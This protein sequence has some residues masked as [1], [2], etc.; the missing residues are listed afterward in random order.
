MRIIGGSLGG[1]HIDTPKGHRTHPMADKIRGALFNAL[2]DVSDLRVLDVFAGGGALG[3]EAISRG[4]SDVIA[5]D[6]DKK[7]QVTIVKNAKS[8]Q[9]QDKLK[10]VQANASSWSTNNPA[11]VFDLVLADPPYDNLQL[12]L[13]QKLGAHV[14]P[15]GL[16]VLSWPGSLTSPAL[17]GLEQV[18]QLCYGDAQLVF[19]RKTE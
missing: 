4:A 2:G 6:A 10:A 9:V 14:K 8:L 15:G 5:I 19:Y 12:S 11:V 1:R 3:L 13:V 18:K 17:D 7:A 16:Y